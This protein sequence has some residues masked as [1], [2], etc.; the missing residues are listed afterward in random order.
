MSSDPP[1]VADKSFLYSGYFALAY[2]G[3]VNV[4]PLQNDLIAS[5]TP[6]L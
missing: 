3:K 2:Q 6:S 4:L 5:C 1:R